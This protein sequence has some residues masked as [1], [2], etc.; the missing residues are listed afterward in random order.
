VVRTL[1]EALETLA[2][3]GAKFEPIEWSA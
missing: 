2:V 1:D 3:E